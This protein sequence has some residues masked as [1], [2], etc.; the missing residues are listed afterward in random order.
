M[1]WFREPVEWGLTL[2]Y[3]RHCAELAECVFDGDPFCL[4]H[5]E[6]AWERAVAVELLGERAW[7]LLPPLEERA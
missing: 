7:D 5:A 2:C 4:E 1:S 6:E 3:R